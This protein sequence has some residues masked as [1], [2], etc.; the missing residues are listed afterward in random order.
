MFNSPIRRTI[1]EVPRETIYVRKTTVTQKLLRNTGTHVGVSK[2]MDDA[3][4]RR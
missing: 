2:I 1:I 4:I 3:I